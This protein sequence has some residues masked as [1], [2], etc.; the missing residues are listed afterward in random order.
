MKIIIS[1]IITYILTMSILSS[2]LK[3]IYF[4]YFYINTYEILNKKLPLFIIK[5]ISLLFVILEFSIPI[6]ILIN[7][8]VSFFN[9]ILIILIYLAPT[10][11]LIVAIILGNKNLDCGCFG[12][13]LKVHITWGKVLENLFYI[14]ILAYSVTLKDI[15]IKIWYILISIILNILYFLIINRKK[16]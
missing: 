11:I 7:L 2:F 5:I 13:K 8:K 6:F 12:M 3:G 10:I 9:I 14:I 1:I 15:E 4:S 16:G